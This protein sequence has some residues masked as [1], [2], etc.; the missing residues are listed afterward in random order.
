MY[1]ILSIALGNEYIFKLAS[2]INTPITG[3]Q[4]TLSRKIARKCN[5]ITHPSGVLNIKVFP[6]SVILYDFLNLKKH[7]I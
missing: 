6:K 4:H 2:T 5:I 3:P 1:R 7:K